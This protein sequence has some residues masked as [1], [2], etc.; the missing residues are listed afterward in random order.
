MLVFRI[1]LHGDGRT[2]S[3]PH[4]SKPLLSQS[5]QC[6]AKHCKQDNDNSADGWDRCRKQGQRYG[7]RSRV[8]SGLETTAS[9]WTPTRIIEFHLVAFTWISDMHIKRALQYD[10][11]GFMFTWQQA[12]SWSSVAERNKAAVSYLVTYIVF[13]MSSMSVKTV[14]IWLYLNP[15]S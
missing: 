5:T 14:G 11:T 15:H 4:K 8:R 6:S 7:S 10:L 3:L 2:R 13:L 1:P 9:I 12:V